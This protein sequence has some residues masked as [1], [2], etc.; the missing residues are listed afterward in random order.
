MAQHMFIPEHDFLPAARQRIIMVLGFVTVI[1]FSPFALISLWREQTI[2]A[3]FY[4]VIVT[5]LSV[6]SYYLYRKH[7]MLVPP[8]IILNIILV[9]LIHSMSIRGINALFWCYPAVFGVL[10][11]SKRSHARI[12]TVVF[13]SLLV[14]AAFY[15]VPANV[16]A[17]FGVTLLMVSVS[18][19]VLIGILNEFQARLAALTLRDPLTNAYNRRYLI[20]C[21]E[22]AITTAQKS[23]QPATLVAFDIDHFKGINDNY[24]HQAGDDTLTGIVKII[25]ELLEQQYQSDH[26]FRLGG[27]EF[28]ILLKNT[29]VPFGVI[30]AEEIRTRIALAPLIAG[31]QVTV[32]LGVTEYTAGEH[33]DAWL[34]RTD[35]NLYRAKANGRNCV[36][37][38]SHALEET[39]KKPATPPL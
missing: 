9:A 38:S 35:D 3:T 5:L 14:P 21:L 27:E 19:D 4:L 23:A 7:A 6:N 12:N 31:A 13:L 25:D 2:A 36:Y 22:Q 8:W 20:D 10:F 1:F 17:R 26:I 33:I 16:A 24:G 37:A 39:H 15:F 30:F 18:S 29:S 34:K 32:S 11:L 28:L